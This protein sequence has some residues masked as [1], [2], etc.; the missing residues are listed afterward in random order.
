MQ[1]TAVYLL[2][3]EEWLQEPWIGKIM[4][5]LPRERYEKARS[6]KNQKARAQGV[7]A[8]ALL[9]LKLQEDWGTGFMPR[10][11]TGSKGKP[12]LE[13]YPDIFFNYSHCSRGILC[14][15]S[16]C[17]TGADVETVKPYKE[18]LA[19]KVCHPR[20]IRLLEQISDQD[21]RA[22]YFTRMWTA[23]ESYLKYLGCGID[24]D[25]SGIDL[26][27]CRNKSFTAYGARF[28]M[29]EGEGFRASVCREEP[30][31]QEISPGLP[32]SRPFGGI[33]AEKVTGREIL[34]F[35]GLSF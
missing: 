5:L 12:Y 23:K 16:E 27:E 30:A 14:A 18:N 19:R 1:K 17:E 13:D 24:R 6:F 25:L 11:R 32:E 26:S 28:D 35:C 8:Y 9:A 34:S 2:R 4:E 22:A 33:S 15:V 31:G 29:L 10:I 7:L 3:S 21:L 20:E